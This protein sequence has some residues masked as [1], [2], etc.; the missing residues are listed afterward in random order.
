MCESDFTIR[1]NI[2]THCVQEQAFGSSSK[3]F[4]H[5][6]NKSGGA[7]MPFNRDKLQA[8]VQP[9]ARP[10]ALNPS[11]LAFTPSDTKAYCSNSDNDNYNKE[12]PPPSSLSLPKLVKIKPKVESSNNELIEFKQTSMKGTDSSN[13]TSIPRKARRCWSHE[14]HHRFVNALHQLGGP[15]GMYRK[16]MITM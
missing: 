4:F 5:S 16:L 13:G 11:D 6:K 12:S 7:F 8:V 15:Q 2:G 1:K 10:G 9:T 14:L 3:P